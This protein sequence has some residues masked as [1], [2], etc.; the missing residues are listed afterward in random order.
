MCE[1][2][3]REAISPATCASVYPVMSHHLQTLPL[4]LPL[5]LQIS[6]AVKTCAM[7]HSRKLFGWHSGEDVTPSQLQPSQESNPRA[8]G[9]R[10]RFDPKE[11][12]KKR[13]KEV[14]EE[15][16]RV[17]LAKEASTMRSITSFFAK[18]NK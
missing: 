3:H 14:K 18:P 6:H 9:K 7:L 1:A 15:A 4:R 17:T 13:L 10:L 11:L 16:K 5:L 8:G 12:A 2:K